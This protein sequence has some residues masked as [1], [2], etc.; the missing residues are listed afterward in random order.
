M[1]D[2]SETYLKEI[3]VELKHLNRNLSKMT[4]IH[5]TAYKLYKH[6]A[7][8][9]KTCYSCN[10]FDENFCHNNMQS[11]YVTDPYEACWNWTKREKRGEDNVCD[12]GQNVQAD[13][14]E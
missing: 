1:T 8:Q 3:A 6:Q 4:G 7:L 12:E 14:I 2:R 10:W 13:H 9:T 11:E 5:T